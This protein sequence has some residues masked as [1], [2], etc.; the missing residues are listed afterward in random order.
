[1][2]IIQL[3]STN[4]K[5]GFII[6]K[7]PNSLPQIKQLKLGYAFG[8]YTHKEDGTL[9]EQEYNVYFQE[10]INCVS[11]KE[12]T[13][14]D[15]EL[16]YTDKMRF[17]SPL[18]VLDLFDTFFNS[19]IKNQS[20]D[21]VKDTFENKIYINLLW[22]KPSAF[23]IFS[24]VIQNFSKTTGLNFHYE[25]KGENIYSLELRSSNTLQFLLNIAQVLIML[26]VI[27][28]K[29][30]PQINL[31][32]IRAK[33][34][35]SLPFVKDHLP[36]NL[37]YMLLCTLDTKTFNAIV[38]SLQTSN[39]TYFYGRLNER[40]FF[41]VLNEL[42]RSRHQIDNI[43]DIGAGDG[44]YVDLL[45]KLK[46][47]NSKNI[48]YHCL[49]I[50]PEALQKLEQKRINKYSNYKVNIINADENK[51]QPHKSLTLD[52]TQTNV[53][54]MIEVIEHMEFEEAKI[55]LTN[56]IQNIPFNKLILS[57]PN[58]EFNINYSM[59]KKFRHDDHKFEF[60]GLEFKEFI[61]MCCG[62]KQVT[63]KFCGIGD[64]VDEIT[65]TQCVIISKV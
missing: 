58:Y 23:K 32:S 20:A 10:Q 38:P 14:P 42:S 60:I 37:M 43:I 34:K 51:L 50:N 33:L 3:T 8:Y 56:I 54:L 64:I 46:N 6:K 52:P 63:T 48:S 29:I 36:Y 9:L 18:C 55:L 15:S 24:L 45:T 61:T 17:M 59:D 11:Y 12:S 47:I 2:T 19:T 27:K 25:N 31:E 1:M 44:R 13:D 26:I 62:S 28:N 53:I 40:R 57:T 49:D 4:P 5:L 7:N 30:W 41:F 22:I 21:D 65:P 16:D 39:I 35:V